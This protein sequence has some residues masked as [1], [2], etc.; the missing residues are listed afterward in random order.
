M[1]GSLNAKA[2]RKRR[3]ADGLRFGCT[4]C[5]NCCLIDGYVWVDRHEIARLAE[6]FGLSVDDFGSQYLR[7]VGRRYSLIEIPYPGDPSKKACVFWDGR[8]TVY[9]ARPR[10]CRTFPFW[11]ENLAAAGDW[12]AAAKLSPGIDN[13]RLYQLGE[14]EA[15]VRGKGETEPSKD[16]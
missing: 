10:Q 16:S 13:G 4:G 2:E 12:E 6:H 15:L 3:Y 5:G 1:S 7:R 11:A 14:I 8:C 9:E